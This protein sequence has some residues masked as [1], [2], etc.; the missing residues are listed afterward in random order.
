MNDT[1]VKKTSFYLL[2]FL[3]LVI[4]ISFTPVIKYY[5]TAVAVDKTQLVTSEWGSLGSYF[6]G[7]VGVLLTFFAMTLSL[8]SIYITIRTSKQV[9]DKEFQIIQIQNKPMPY[10]DFLKYNDETKIDLQNMGTGTMI[11]TKIVILESDI[12][13]NR[14]E[15]I[16]YNN[17]RD[18]LKDKGFQ[19]VYLQDKKLPIEIYYNTAPT[20]IIPSGKSKELLNVKFNSLEMSKENREKDL[21][22]YI[23]VQNEIREL[24]RNYTI[25]IFYKDIFDKEFNFDYNLS[26]FRPE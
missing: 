20:Y 16:S 17:F 5:T 2:A 3:L 23:D 9:K 19:I 7:T 22:T 4:G 14:T 1:Q 15:E 10:F 6:S 21:N 13:K 11:V 8:I 25:K 12:N 18:L 24:I 26:F